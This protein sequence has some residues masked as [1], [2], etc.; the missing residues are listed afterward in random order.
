LFVIADIQSVD[1]ANAQRQAPASPSS[2]AQNM[3]LVPVRCC[4]LFGT[5]AA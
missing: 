2:T 4:V 5:A 1:N 3:T